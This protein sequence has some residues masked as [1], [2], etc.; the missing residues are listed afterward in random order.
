MMLRPLVKHAGGKRAIA[1]VVHELLGRPRAL[2]EP[3]AGGLAVSLCAGARPRFVA[4]AIPAVRSIYDALATAPEALWAQL[5]AVPDVIEDEA[6][7]YA[8]RDAFNTCQTPGR[9]IA[10]NYACYNGLPRFN[11]AGEFNAP[12]GRP[13]P[14]RIPHFDALRGAYASAFLG[15]EVFA[16]WRP[17]VAAAAAA[18]VPIYADPPY[19]G[20]FGYAVAPW[21]AYEL[22][23]LASSLPVGSALSER[24]G[25]EGEGEESPA[26]VLE[27]CGYELA[28]R[29]TARDSVSCGERSARAEGVW[30]RAGR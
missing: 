12:V 29:W 16:D 22:F 6:A 21:T 24:L 9:Y 15:T 14:R 23:D 25:G 4:D 13:L 19:V 26:A 18:G 27:M 2:C 30:V 3:F 17:C 10:L 8:L 5:D 7:F 11:Q 20:T 28:H 1:S